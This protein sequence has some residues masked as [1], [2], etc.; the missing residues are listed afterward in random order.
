MNDLKYTVLEIV[1]LTAEHFTKKNIP[2]ARLIAEILLSSILKCS[3]MELYLNFDKPLQTA[4]LNEY[5]ELVK[6]RLAGEPLQYILGKAS[7]YRSEFIV[8]K[9]VLIPRAE[10][11]I[12]VENV[13]KDI[14]A[15]ETSEINIYEIGT[16]SGCISI[17]IAKELVSFEKPVHITSTDI[18]DTA[19]EIAEIN[20][21]N[22]LSE[23]SNS[24]VKFIKEDIFTISSIDEKFD[25]II[26]NPPYIPLNEYNE[27]E[28]H[29]KDHE[30]LNSLT[31]N[32]DGISFY[33]KIIEAAK[34]SKR[35]IYFEIAY[36]AKEKLEEL[37][38]DLGIKN[39]YFIK[40]LSDNFR[41]LKIEL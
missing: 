27:L 1:K 35:K 30:P 36:N 28:K 39:Y 21:K 32:S 4:E 17:S 16:G 5:R 9:N 31:D 15:T 37:L 33:K 2:E 34:G 38:N 10:T 8:N 3:R 22:L 19:L 23:D 41:V 6:R 18:S 12:L 24:K 26:S 11:E 29:V 14:K 20:K 13:L 40:D 25:F 7:F